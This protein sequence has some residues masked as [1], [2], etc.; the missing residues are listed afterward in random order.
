MSPRDFTAGRLSEMLMSLNNRAPGSLIL[1]GKP[2]TLVRW[3]ESGR[4]SVVMALH[5][6][7]GIKNATHFGTDFEEK[8]EKDTE[9]G[10]QS[11]SSQGSKRITNFS[12]KKSGDI[13]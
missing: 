7:R 2:L 10:D 5:G 12:A 11:G 13:F 9:F 6:G 1:P 3:F 8:T 4:R